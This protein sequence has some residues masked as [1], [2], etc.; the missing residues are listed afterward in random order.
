MYT[1]INLITGDLSSQKFF[2]PVVS[3][4]LCLSIIITIGTEIGYRK[5]SDLTTLSFLATF[6]SVMNRQNSLDER[7]NHLPSSFKKVDGQKYNKVKIMLV[8]ITFC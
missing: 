4:I 1:I 5:L 7:D 3:S 8:V 2:I 6:T